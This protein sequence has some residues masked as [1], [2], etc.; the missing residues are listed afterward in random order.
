MR[1]TEIDALRRQLERQ[2][3]QRFLLGSG[4]T[5]LIAGT[6]TLTLGSAAWL[7]WLLVV[8]GTGA[9][10]AARPKRREW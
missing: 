8:G 9:M 10:F 3:R 5:A 6:L 2:Q 7:G 1:S 4:G